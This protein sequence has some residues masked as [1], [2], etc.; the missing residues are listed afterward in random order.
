[1]ELND[2]LSLL[3]KGKHFLKKLTSTPLM[4]TQKNPN[5]AVADQIV[6]SWA[7]GKPLLETTGKPSGYYR[8]T[9]YLRDYIATHN[10]LP[11]GIHTMP[12]GRDSNN[13]IEPSFPVDFDTI[14]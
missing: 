8:L 4:N 9:N 10:T 3:Q 13:N 1:M 14:P 12:E 11:T 6:E 2:L 5:Q 7:K